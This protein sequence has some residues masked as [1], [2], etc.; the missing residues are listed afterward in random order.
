MR[1]IKAAEVVIDM[2]IYPRNN[3]D[4]H[5]VRSIMDAIL[6]G[7]QIPP[8]L[9][10]RKSKR[11]IDGVHRTKAVLRLDENGTIDVIEKTYKS[12]AD[13]LLEAMRLNADHG[14][15]LDPCDRVR[16]VLLGEK[17]G[18]PLDAIAG[19][20]HM[21]MEKLGALRADRTAKTSGGLAI[22][23]KR[24]FRHMAGH[25]LSKQQQEVNE[26]SSGMNAAFYANQLIS[27]IEADMLDKEDEKLVER[28]RCLHEVLERVLVAE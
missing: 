1:T 24:T 6:A 13:M 7:E 21:P 12:E 25:R 14:A 3:V 17:L 4:E 8:I 18:I 20:L 10:D 16:C 27:M 2:T 22:P 26:R 11:A 5:N 28:L 15:R 9:I 23:L 19:A